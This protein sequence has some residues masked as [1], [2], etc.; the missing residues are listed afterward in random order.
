MD[1]RDQ[2][3]ISSRCLIWQDE[4]KAGCATGF[5]LEAK[6][7]ISIGYCFPELMLPVNIY[8]IREYAYLAQKLFRHQ[9]QQSL[10]LAVNVIHTV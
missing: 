6:T 1:L 5:H 10:N 7:D 8:L 9:F 2:H 3:L 4:H